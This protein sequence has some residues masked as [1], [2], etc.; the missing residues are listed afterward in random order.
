MNITKEDKNDL[1]AVLRIDFEQ[2]DYMPAYEKAL[3]NYRK[4]LNLP[5][6]RQ[7]HVPMGIVKKRFG[8]GLLADEING[9]INNSLSEYIREQKLDVLGNPMP[10][11]DVEDVGDWDNPDSFQFSYD[12][13][14][15]PQFEVKIDEKS[16]FEFYEVEVTDE[17]VNKEVEALTRRH[18]A[19]TDV[20]VSNEN[21]LLLG[22]FV[23]LDENDEI[24]EG[25]KMNTSSISIEF[26]PDEKTKK[27]LIGLKAD[28]H[29]VV[30]PHH[31]SSGNEDLARMLNIDKSEAA[32]V[33]NNYRF[34]VKEVKEMKPAALEPEFFD[35]VFGP[36]EVKTEEEF[37]ARL[38]ESIAQNFKGD[39]QQL[40]KREVMKKLEKSLNLSLPDDL[41][42]RWIKLS[43][44]E[45][46]EDEEL[47]QQYPEYA[48]G[49]IW[50]LIQNKL[51]EG[52]GLKVEADE[53]IDYTKSIVANNFQQ[54]G[55]PVPEDEQLDEYAKNALQNQD[56]M[57]KIY[58]RLYD[59]K[60]ME[61]IK[62]TAKIKEVKMS[63]EK[64]AE[65]AEQG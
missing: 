36:G 37:R 2:A 33:S 50:Q 13:A 9:M 27:K 38:K 11:E 63:F 64:F 30:D 41:L 29:V 23:E 43:N 1:S 44:E 24:V 47:E 3:K 12:L 65:F 32:Q 55:M 7:G 48:R 54:Y 16:E 8:K 61:K 60:L 26:V 22:A 39:S 15:A 25:G 40:F 62:E 14:L 52:F 31:V 46:I 28:D 58:E 18:G 51:I 56:E 21:A 49:L 19:V 20:E 59:I 6:F 5:G 17:M 45:P 10:S 35:K 34:N 42:K 53:V 57:R 4:Q